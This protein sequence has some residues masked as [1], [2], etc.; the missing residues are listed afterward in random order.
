MEN[1][2]KNPGYAPD[3]YTNMITARSHTTVAGHQGMLIT[4]SWDDK[5]KAL[6]RI[7][8]IF[9]SSNGQWY[10][11]DN[12]PKPHYWLQ[13]VIVD[14]ILYLLGGYD[15]GN[16]CSIYCSTECSVKIPAEVEY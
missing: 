7:E 5:N 9:D 4:G 14:N 8:L 2:F 12:R 1:P 11:C 16:S 10:M 13:S 15:E 6:S 3:N